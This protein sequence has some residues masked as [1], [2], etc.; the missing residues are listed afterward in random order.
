MWF[1]KFINL[2]T[3]YNNFSTLI[4]TTKS[5]FSKPKVGLVILVSVLAKNTFS[6]HSKLIQLF[7]V[8]AGKNIVFSRWSMDS[9][10]NASASKTTDL[11]VTE[12]LPP[13]RK[14]SVASVHC[15]ICYDN[16]KPEELIAPCHCKVS[17]HIYS[18]HC[19]QFCLCF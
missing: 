13:G 18:S 1:L 7:I 16:D 10:A 11:K 6:D 14:L 2:L 19:L 12:D 3:L 4:Q 5:I 15:R 17:W 8:K 9:E